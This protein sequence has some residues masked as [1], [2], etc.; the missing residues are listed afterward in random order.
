MSTSELDILI[1]RC[2]NEKIPNGEIDLPVALEI[3][4]VIRSRRVSPKDSMRCLK[5]RALNTRNN[6]N[7]QFA[8]WRLVEVCMKNGGVPFLKEVC[9]REFMDCLE[10][11]ILSDSTDDDLEKFCARLVAE[12][13]LAFKNDSQLSYVVKVYQKLMARGIDMENLQPTENLNAMFDA[14]TPADWID[15]D[16]C[17]ICSNK[18]TL[19]N[20]RHHCRSCGGIFCQ[21]HSSRYIPLPDLG[22]LEPVRVCDNCFDDYDLKKVSKKKKSK[23]SSKSH[24]E[25]DDLRKAIELSLLESNSSYQADTVEPVKVELPVQEDEEDP[26]LK[27]AIEASLAEHREQEERQKT[28]QQHL[29]SIPISNQDKIQQKQST[30]DLTFNEEEDIQLFAS[31]VERMK[32]QPVTAI[33][34]DTQLQQLYQKVIATRPKL[35]Y[36]INDTVTK[37]NTLFE[38][39]SKISDIMNIYDS[40]LERQLRNITISQQFPVPQ[41]REANSYAYYQSTSP[42]YSTEPSE[43]TMEL[44]QQKVREETYLSASS[45]QAEPAPHQQEQTVPISHQLEGLVIDQPKELPYPSADEHISR[46]DREEIPSEPPYPEDDIKE[47][48]IT[49]YDFPTVPQ[50]KLS[51]YETETSMGEQSVPQEKLLIEL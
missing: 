46:K 24:S 42:T 40:M 51:T 28:Q 9:S 11:V 36:A 34:E 47:Q 17:M 7:T 3:S 45:N 4:D 23:K 33:L 32:T 22:I 29:P 30:Y 38:M 19:L 50:R 35:N 44:N 21:E 25:E 2:T 10:T 49:N 48:N 26:E 14:K 20:R 39:N 6:Q 27:A 1:E 15:S 43:P 18:F 41:Q 16:A 5:K 31:L 37:Y 13:Y 12:L 8:V